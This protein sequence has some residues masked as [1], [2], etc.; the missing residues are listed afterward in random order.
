MESEEFDMMLFLFLKL[1]KKG[2]QN[3]KKSKGFGSG[4]FLRNVSFFEFCQTGK[5]IS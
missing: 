2:S 5:D 1:R 3:V 4:K